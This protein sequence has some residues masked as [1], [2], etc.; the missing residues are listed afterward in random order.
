MTT[1]LF[2]GQA[3]N[4]GDADR[5]WATAGEVAYRPATPEDIPEMISVFLAALADLNARQNNKAA[6]P[7]RS[8]I[9]VDFEHGLETGSYH[10][11]EID[12]S[13][14]AIAGAIVRDRLWFLSGFWAVP[15]AQHR[16]I[17]MPLLRRVWQ[18]G[19]EAGA[20]IFFTWAS[21]DPA[22]MAAYMKMGMLPG[23]QILK[24]EGVPCPVPALPAGYEVSPL[25]PAVA[26]ALDLIILGTQRRDD[27]TFWRCRAG[28]VGRELIHEGQIAGYYYVRNGKI[29]PAGW[30]EP[31]HAPALLAAAV[32][33]AAQTAPAIRLSVPGMNHTALRYALAVGLRLTGFAHLLTNAPLLRLPYY[34]PSGPALF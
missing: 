9:A 18:D 3:T 8:V 21:S 2:D 34:L 25:E 33:E 4:Q 11:A 5:Y 29:G 28:L 10:V 20:T 30:T 17:G 12:G 26:M 23:S 27:H 7:L 16:G 32:G 31:R 19:K 22:A 13:I 24:F 15:A 6:L 1:I 14:V